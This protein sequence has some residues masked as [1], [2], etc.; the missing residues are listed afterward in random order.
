MAYQEPLQLL[1]R[2][3]PITPHVEGFV[4]L[5]DLKVELFT[6]C[7]L[8]KLGQL[9]LDLFHYL[10]FTLKQF[11]QRAHSIVVLRPEDPATN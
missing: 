3:A 11:S 5:G 9:S 10:N 7:A 2:K 4:K 1:A 6:R 8:G